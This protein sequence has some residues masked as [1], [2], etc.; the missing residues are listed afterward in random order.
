MQLTNNQVLNALQGLNTLTN[1]KLPIKLAWKVTTAIRELE[2]F[3]KAVEQPVQDIRVKYAVRDENGAFLEA[4]NES[5][6]KIPNT[7]QIPTEKITLLNT[8]LAELM[9][10]TV[11]VHNV[12][13]SLDDFPETFELEPAT[14]N[15]LMP[16]FS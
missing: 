11:E 14:L 8:E 5:G 10:A 7:M 9:A 15:L 4:L 16:L 2:V 12:S 13:L 3:A 6:E 1:N